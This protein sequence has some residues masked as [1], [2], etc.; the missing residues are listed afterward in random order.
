MLLTITTEHK[1]AT[2]L[3]FLLH[4]H[5][6]RFQSFDFSYG[7]AHVFYPEAT[8]E[9][10]TACL[11]LDVDPVGMVRG[12]QSFQVAQYVNDRPYVASSFMSV[13]I[14]QLFNTAMG[15]R[16]KDRPQLVTTPI[17]LVAR[18]EVLPVRGGENFLQRIFE[19]IG[20]SVE[21]VRH[22]LD[23]HFPEWGESDYYSVTISG[24]KTL[25][26]LLT[27]LYVLIPVFDNDKHYFVGEDEMQKLL[28]KGEGW[29]SS[30]P[31]KEQITRR[32]LKNLSS[33]YSQTLVQLDERQDIET[34][35]NQLT[36]VQEELLETSFSLNDQRLGAVMATLRASGARTILDLGCGEGKLLRDLLQDQQFE[37]IVGMDVSIRS[38]EMAQKRLKLD[39]IPERLGKRL[40]LL[41]GSL[42]YRDK[43]LEGFDAAAVVEVIEHL[44]PPRLSAFERVIFEF[45]KPRTVLIT[46][47][48]REYNVMWKTLPAGQFRHSDHRF[49]WNRQEFQD[50]ANGVAEQ[51]GYSVRFLPVGPEDE[52]VGAPTQMGVFERV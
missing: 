44:D 22:P 15:G 37:Q 45:A 20:Y 47:P 2:D 35:E 28:S 30:H 33:L 39:Q 32:Y 6:D 41:H 48:N 3:G 51:H 52:K 18:L 13:A 50:W 8:E 14:S 9:R 1:P 49:E 46:T 42:I 34:A 19:P 27:H 21:A 36:K 10:C 5:P 7:K 17:P 12:K 23:E 4:K 24:T 31:E 11:L 26:E 16:C 40:N 25:S 43:R 38:L 29:L